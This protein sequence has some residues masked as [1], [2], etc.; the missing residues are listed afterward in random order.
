MKYNFT[1]L[2]NDYMT[3]PEVYQPILK[4]LGRDKFDVDVCCTKKNIPA[5]V[6][7]VNGEIDGLKAEWGKVNW[8][9][10]PFLTCDKWIKKA[11]EEQ[12]K[13]NTTYSILPVRT[14]TAYWR[15]Y[16]LNKRS[17]KINWI[18]KNS[19]TGVTFI[20]PA[21]GDYVRDKNGNKGLFKNPLAI[22]I[23]KGIK[24]NG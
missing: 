11:H 20:D 10:P 13:G 22:V 1:T 23:F 18:T 12:K 6:H 3:P 21:T 17:V 24:K 2:S 16:I 15:D 7:F 5:V 4:K 9:N 8:L 14:E 19:K